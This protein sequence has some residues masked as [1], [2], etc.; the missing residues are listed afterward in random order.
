MADSDEQQHHNAENVLS[1]HPEDV[2]ADDHQG[3]SDSRGDNVGYSEHIQAACVAASSARRARQSEPLPDHDDRVRKRR[4][5]NLQSVR[6]S[7]NRKKERVEQYQYEASRLQHVNSELKQENERLESVL[8]EAEWVIRTRQATP[9]LSFVGNAASGN[10]F[11]PPSS[12]PPIALPI[13]QSMHSVQQF[14]KISPMLPISKNANAHVWG[15]YRRQDARNTSGTKQTKE[16][17]TATSFASLQATG[18]GG[19]STMMRMNTTFQNTSQITEELRQYKPNLSETLSGTG[20]FQQQQQQQQ[21]ALREMG[22]LAGS[23]GFMSL[24][25]H[26]QDS[27]NKRHME[28]ILQG[29]IQNSAVASPMNN[30]FSM[31][32]SAK[33]PPP[34]QINHSLLASIGQNYLSSMASSSSSCYP[35]SRFEA[36]CAAIGNEQILSHSSL[37]PQEDPAEGVKPR[38]CLH[39]AYYF[40]SSALNTIKL[41]QSGDSK[42]S[43]RITPPAAP[44][45]PLSNTA[46]PQLVSLPSS[47]PAD[48]ALLD[49]TMEVPSVETSNCLHP[50]FYFGTMA[51]GAVQLRQVSAEFPKP[52]MMSVP[53]LLASHVKVPKEISFSTSMSSTAGAASGENDLDDDVDIGTRQIRSSSFYYGFTN[54][55][56][57]RRPPPQADDLLDLSVQAD[58]N[59][60]DGEAS[61]YSSFDEEVNM[62]RL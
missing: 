62:V 17:P 49:N 59:S 27:T 50:S 13:P 15:T 43:A 54:A 53:S 9:G 51:P 25:H 42:P 47:T 5:S 16:P 37:S 48:A 6:Q 30:M 32:T 1:Y 8:K 2:D 18:G 11:H 3:T 41:R 33:T 56:C 21:Q 39:P 38:S 34:P 55:L 23:G 31:L 35:Q 10:P 20:T 57:H 14:S 46:S 36:A 12:T 52:S 40:G 29:M 44:P 24:Q 22:S 4:I 7:R 26:F 19:N 61:C 45:K 58:C 60:I 28:D